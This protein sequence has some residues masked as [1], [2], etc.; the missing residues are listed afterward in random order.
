LTVFFFAAT[1]AAAP[2]FNVNGSPGASF[3]EPEVASSLAYDASW[4]QDVPCAES[5]AA[6]ASAAKSPELLLLLPR[7]TLEHE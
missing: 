6:A 3:P 7:P 5:T 2:A 4:L 1:A